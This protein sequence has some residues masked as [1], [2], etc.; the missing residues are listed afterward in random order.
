MV[1]DL[2][3]VA[4]RRRKDAI[5][6]EVQR[7]I[8]HGI[9]LEGA[10]ASGAGV[11]AALG[12]RTIVALAEHEKIRGTVRRGVSVNRRA[13]ALPE[14]H[15]NVLY[16][17]NAKTVKTGLPNPILIDIGHLRAHISALGSEIIQTAQLAQ[18]GRAHV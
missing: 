10:A 6:R 15:V 3:G 5:D 4:I 14:T 1:F 11:G 12:F 18:I 9:E 17:I 16:G 2:F 8:E 7:I 13:P